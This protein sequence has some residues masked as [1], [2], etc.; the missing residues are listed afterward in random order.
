MASPKLAP[1][2]CPNLNPDTTTTTSLSQWRRIIMVFFPNFHKITKASMSIM[3]FSKGSKETKRMT[4]KKSWLSFT[5]YF[6]GIP[7]Q[8]PAPKSYLKKKLHAISTPL[9]N[10]G[11]TGRNVHLILPKVKTF[12]KAKTFRGK[13]QKSCLQRD[14]A[15]SQLTLRD[16]ASGRPIAV[17]VASW[18]A[19]CTSQPAASPYKLISSHQALKRP[20]TFLVERVLN[21]S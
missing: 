14:M 16:L 7:T 6:R 20:T 17:V 1:A 11:D 15:N 18:K 10:N 19:I 13:D 12:P 9:W 4:S 8:Y 21:N 2:E 5:Y 3:Q